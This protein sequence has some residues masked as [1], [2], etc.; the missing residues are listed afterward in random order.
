MLIWSFFLVQYF[1]FCLQGD[2]LH[3]GT[4]SWEPSNIGN[5]RHE[6]LRQKQENPPSKYLLVKLSES[7][8]LIYAM[9]S[10]QIKGL[11]SRP[12]QQSVNPTL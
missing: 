9:E 8:L 10:D 6:N 12:C 3:Q 2:Q 7:K 1:H 11:F 5:Y 4:S